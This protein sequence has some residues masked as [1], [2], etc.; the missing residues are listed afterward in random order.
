MG[1]SDMTSDG[2]GWVSSKTPA[3]EEI[4]TIIDRSRE[5]MFRSV[6]REL[7]DM[8]WEIGRSISEKTKTYKTATRKQN[9]Q[10][11]GRA[12]KVVRN[13]AVAGTAVYDRGIGF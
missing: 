11:R 13:E 5:R 7:I 3:F 8:Y 6:N 10:S 12:K 1:R 9:R 4:V 2:I